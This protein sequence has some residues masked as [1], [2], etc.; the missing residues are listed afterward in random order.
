MKLDLLLHL[1]AHEPLILDFSLDSPRCSRVALVGTRL[2]Q[3]ARFGRLAARAVPN[4][5]K[6]VLPLTT[7]T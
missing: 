3:F 7:A 5:G 1:A 2:R 6:G 4:R